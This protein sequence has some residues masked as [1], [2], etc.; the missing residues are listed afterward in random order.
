MVFLFYPIQQKNNARLSIFM[1]ESK[2]I[3]VKDIIEKLKQTEHGFKHIIEAGDLLLKDQKL[4]H[5]NFAGHLLDDESYQ[6]RMLGTYLLGEL[7]PAD[8]KALEILK[9]N[10]S[11]DDNWRVQEMLA[12][13]FDSYCHAIDYE[14][15]VPVIKKWLSDPNPNVKRA[16]TEGLRIWTSRKYFKENPDIAIQLI[17]A[18]CADES[19]YLR[20]SVGNA[21]RDI[22]K[23]HPDLIKN[24]LDQWDLSDKNVAFT[25]KLVTKN[26]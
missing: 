19:E 7:A 25:K 4:D 21:L 3:T 18:H 6:A 2:G 1:A 12:K 26:D 23:K 17:S 10:V 14:K 16:V 20:K 11:K 5:F 22:G 9:S 24:E 13:S 8:E 15:A